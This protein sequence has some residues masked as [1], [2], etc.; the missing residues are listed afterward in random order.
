MSPVK[1][2]SHIVQ[3]RW[4]DRDRVGT[5]PAF[6]YS[7]RYPP[8][9]APPSRHYERA[10]SR[11]RERAHPAV[12]QLSGKGPTSSKIDRSRPLSSSLRHRESLEEYARPTSRHVSTS[13]RVSARKKSSVVDRESAPSPEKASYSALD[14][15]NQVPQLRPESSL[16][17]MTEIDVP[18]LGCEFD[19]NP[20]S[21]GVHFDDFDPNANGGG[22]FDEFDPSSPK[23]SA[24]DAETIV[25]ARRAD[26][27][28]SMNVFPEQHRR[29]QKSSRK[30]TTSSGHRRPSARTT[31]RRG[32]TGTESHAYRERAPH[33]ARGVAA[34]P[35]TCAGYLLLKDYT[36][37]TF[38]T[39]ASRRV[40]SAKP[41]LSSGGV[42]RNS[43]RTSEGDG[44]VFE[45]GHRPPSRQRP[46]PEALHLELPLEGSQ[47]LISSRPNCPPAIKRASW[48]INTA[49]NNSL[50]P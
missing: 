36:F 9:A 24:D 12:S 49:M 14:P 7:H 34:R 11:V 40:Q 44:S 4:T 26:S 47:K 33:A 46:P 17:D 37:G 16:S 32:P 28:M 18:L 20:E 19:P 48:V 1:T 42:G 41:S 31:R 6:P 27:S 25:M 30:K 23:S 8:P 2:G 50:N 43:G 5:A 39:S 15:I 38:P 29:R 22:H 35:K 3:F 13:G 21:R 45:P 10:A